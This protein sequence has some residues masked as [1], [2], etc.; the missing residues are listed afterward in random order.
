VSSNHSWILSHFRVKDIHGAVHLARSFSDHL[1]KVAC[2]YEKT[3]RG[4]PIVAMV[5]PGAPLDGEPCPLCIEAF[6][7]PTTPV[8]PAGAGE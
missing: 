4:E 3:H 5:P 7:P 1:G 2:G 6:T 8:P